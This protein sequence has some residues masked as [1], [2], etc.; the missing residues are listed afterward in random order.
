AT[1]SPELASTNNNDNNNSNALDHIH[2][3]GLNNKQSL[4]K[5]KTSSQ[6]LQGPYSSKSET[7]SKKSGTRLNAAFSSLN[8]ST[9]SSLTSSSSTPSSSFFF[10]KD[11]FKD[12]Y[13]DNNDSSKKGKLD[14][15]AKKTFYKLFGR[16]RDHYAKRNNDLKDIAETDHLHM[17]NKSPES[18]S[19]M[20]N[21]QHPYNYHHH[22]DDLLSLKDP[23]HELVN[24]S[25]ILNHGGAHN[26]NSSNFNN[27]NN[28]SGLNTTNL[29]HL[30]KQDAML[31]EREYHYMYDLLKNTTSLESQF[32]T[33]KP[34]LRSKILN[35]MIFIIN[36]IN[37]AVINNDHMLPK[38]ENL[39]KIILLFIKLTFLDFGISYDADP[40]N[41]I[42]NDKSKKNINNGSYKNSN[43]NISGS[44]SN[45]SISSNTVHAYSISSSSNFSNGISPVN[46]KLL[47]SVL[48]AETSSDLF[49]TKNMSSH[50]LEFITK[51]FYKFI[52]KF[53]NK[54]FKDLVYM[55]E[56]QLI[57]ENND[58]KI[59]NNSIKR[60][61]L[62]WYNFNFH[63]IPDIMILNHEFDIFTKT[64][65]EKFELERKKSD[66]K[67][68]LLETFRD[69]VIMPIFENYDSLYFKQFLSKQQELNNSDK[70][71]F[72]QCLGI[73][74]LGIN[75]DIEEQ[76]QLIIKM[77]ISALRENMITNA[78]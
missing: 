41:N 26:N 49:E 3:N 21:H 19:V 1:S 50:K 17:N 31:S 44:T 59:L 32:V 75:K 30:M 77:L 47:H 24:V 51:T 72:L 46:G 57:Y 15:N 55:I 2:S 9:T 11:E 16:N 39:H 62:I 53:Y 27:N 64:Y 35:N 38:M 37:Y 10:E 61:N 34:K 58:E 60:L 48:S 78:I 73:L 14:Q 40:Q 13:G 4:H 70:L 52:M 25:K 43:G 56:N 67:M 22:F 5:H 54:I 42:Q 74:Q 76:N 20:D 45:S 63:Y 7:K 6:N 8:S 29:D 71:V 65:L 23:E 12:N 33:L 69:C 66:L 68:L 36:D 18:S 28:S